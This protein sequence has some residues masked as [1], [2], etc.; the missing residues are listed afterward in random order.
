MQPTTGL[1][2]LDRNMDKDSRCSFFGVGW[3]VYV[4]TRYLVRK[5]YP[6]WSIN[7]G[8]INAS[9]E[10]ISNARNRWFILYYHVW[11]PAWIKIHSNS[12]W[13]RARSHIDLTRWYWGECWDGLWTLSLGLSQFHGHGSWLMCKVALKTSYPLFLID[14]M[15]CN[16]W[17]CFQV[18]IYIDNKLYTL[19]FVISTLMSRNPRKR[20]FKSHPLLPHFSPLYHKFCH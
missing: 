18:E 19:D 7:S 14:A 17:D 15:K 20:M 2:P 13:L 16:F 1:H 12:I 9:F 3:L 11:G 5:L 8:A 4:L 10:F 6:L